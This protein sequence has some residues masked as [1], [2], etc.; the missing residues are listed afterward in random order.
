[1]KDPQEGS[2]EK[3]RLPLLALGRSLFLCGLL[4]TLRRCL[5]ALG[6]LLLCRLLALRRCLFSLGG[7]F[8]SRLA[9][10]LRR[11]YVVGTRSNEISAAARIDCIVSLLLIPKIK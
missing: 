4:A 3:R 7:L 11:H 6:G 1:M 2:F 8:L 5:L 10:F 9:L